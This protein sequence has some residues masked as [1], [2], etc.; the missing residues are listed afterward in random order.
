MYN[1]L[2]YL[3]Q[4][5]DIFNFLVISGCWYPY[6]ILLLLFSLNLWGTINILLLLINYILRDVAPLNC[7]GKCDD[8]HHVIDNRGSGY[9]TLKPFKSENNVV[10][11][12]VELTVTQHNLLF[13]LRTGSQ[14]SRA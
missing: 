3:I 5:P 8:L 7:P 11:I 2:I 13:W 1:T 12:N 6:H 14:I 10:A 4:R 9:E